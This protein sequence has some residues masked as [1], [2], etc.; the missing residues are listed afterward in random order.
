MGDNLFSMSSPEV[1][2][3][4]STDERKLTGIFFRLSMRLEIE[5]NAKEFVLCIHRKKCWFVN[6]DSVGKLL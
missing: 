4:E 6:D 3:S 5:G 2:P 1:E